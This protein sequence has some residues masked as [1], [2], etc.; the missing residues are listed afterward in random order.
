MEKGRQI[1]IYKY[2]SSAV[3]DL[4][5]KRSRKGGGVRELTLMAQ[6]CPRARKEVGKCCT[7]LTFNPKFR[8]S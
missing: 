3:T 8:K 6:I 7:P 4:D 2:V 5:N 1:I